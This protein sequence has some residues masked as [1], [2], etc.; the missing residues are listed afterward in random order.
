[1]TMVEYP[2]D[3]CINMISCMANAES[4][5]LTIYGNW[6]TLQVVQQEAAVMD[7]M[8]DQRNA[9]RRRGREVAIVKAERQF[10]NEFKKA[11]VGQTQVTIEPVENP[12][13]GD[14]WLDC[15]RTRKSPVYNVLRG[16]QVMTAIRL[17]VDSY[18]E[19][20]VMLFDPQTRRVIDKPPAR[21]EYLPQ[22][23]S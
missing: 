5:P 15:M 3:Y 10:E 6:G 22:E 4:V 17:G 19:G 12:D 16:Y 9:G 1:M 7:A 8:G 21:K 14:D 13:L 11:N 23:A 2:G 18:R 20:R